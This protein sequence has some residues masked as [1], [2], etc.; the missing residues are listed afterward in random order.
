L[1]VKLSIDICWRPGTVVAYDAGGGGK[2]ATIRGTPAPLDHDAVMF[3]FVG[4]DPVTGPP[5][6]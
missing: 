6:A 3:T 4:H 5:S 2:A 1:R